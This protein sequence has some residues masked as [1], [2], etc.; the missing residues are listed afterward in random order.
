MPGTSKAPQDTKR[1]TPKKLTCTLLAK[2]T[3]ERANG[4]TGRSA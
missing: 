3:P 1:K 4:G 2:Y